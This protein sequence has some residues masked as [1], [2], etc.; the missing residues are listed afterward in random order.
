MIILSSTS[1]KI[2]VVTGSAGT[3]DVHASWADLSSGSVTPGRTNTPVITTATTTDVVA[4]PG[5]SA[6]RNVRTMYIRNDDASVDNL[7]SVQHTDGTNVEILWEGILLPGEAVL[8]DTSGRWVKYSDNG[9][10]IV[11]VDT[12]AQLFGF[13]TTSQAGFAADTYVTGSFI[14]FPRAPR[15]GPVSSCRFDATKTAAGPA[16]P[17]LQVRI[18]TSASTGDTSRA[19]HT[20]GVGTAVAST[21]TFEMYVLFR[22]IGAS[23][24]IQTRSTLDSLPSSGISSTLKSVVATSAAF[25]TTVADS[26]VGLSFNGGASFSGTIQLVDATL[27]YF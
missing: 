2:Q 18:G 7:I 15:V 11:D 3:I 20:Y 14:K 1:D 5:A 26:G 13:S 22:S 25:D 27:L 17:I 8:K 21:G 10:K 23:G 6:Q 12:G 24:V 4:S 9:A 16:A 19:S